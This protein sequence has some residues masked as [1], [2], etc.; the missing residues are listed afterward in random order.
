MRLFG[1]QAVPQIQETLRQVQSLENQ[2]TRYRISTLLIAELRWQ[3]DV[4]AL[5]LLSCLEDLDKGSASL[6]C[7]ALGLLKL[8]ASA[9]NVWQCYLRLKA[10]PQETHFVG[11]LWGLIDLGDPRVGGELSEFLHQNRYFYELFGFLSL[12][13]DEQ[14]LSLLISQA[15]E[16][17]HG[18]G[19]DALMAATSIA[20]RVGRQV[21]VHELLK[22][23]HPDQGNRDPDVQAQADEIASMILSRPM[24]EVE[25]YFTLFY[26]GFQPQD[27]RV[28]DEFIHQ[29]KG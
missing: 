17:D 10:Q 28:A 15:M 23:A 2:E 9:E 12:A 5:A 18:E 3:G 27:A 26:R 14:A 29:N 21:L 25:E 1:P 6:A 4:G 11:G 7:A 13:G 16:L 20:H 8:P 19:V 24:R 22:S